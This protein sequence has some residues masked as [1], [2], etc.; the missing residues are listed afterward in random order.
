MKRF[1]ESE[2]FEGKIMRKRV[3]ECREIA[4]QAIAEGG[5]SDNAID[6]FI[7]NIFQTNRNEVSQPF[8]N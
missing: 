1:M 8:F 3:R 4:D 5:S 6:A 2:S 7:D